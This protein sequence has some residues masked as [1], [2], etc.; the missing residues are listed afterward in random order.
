MN[1][2]CSLTFDGTAATDVCYRANGTQTCHI[3]EAEWCGNCIH[4]EKNLQGY[5][6][7]LHTPDM[8][9]LANQ[10]YEAG[11]EAC[12]DWE[13]VEEARHEAELD[14]LLQGWAVEYNE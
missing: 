4:C 3:C 11:M 14:G 8:V 7:T 2:H 12:A 5:Y 13:G 10:E 6:C 9:F 1:K